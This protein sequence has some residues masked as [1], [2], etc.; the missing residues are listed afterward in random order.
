MIAA[1]RL[2]ELVPIEN[3]AMPGRTVIQ[4]EKDDLE[5]LGLLKVDVL[6]LGMLSAIRRALDLLNGYWFEGNAE[7]AKERK[8]RREFYETTSQSS[9]RSLRYSVPSA[10]SGKWTLTLA[11]ATAADSALAHPMGAGSD[12]VCGRG[13]AGGFAGSE[14]LARQ[15]FFSPEAK[16]PRNSR[17]AA[18]RRRCRPPRRRPRTPPSRAPSSGSARASA[19]P[20]RLP[21]GLPC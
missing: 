8:D 11:E 12:H 5:A 16:D 10:F 6:A 14:A 20:D 13:D 15:R 21:A 2:D 3:A 19:R 4:W 17:A 18:S 9:L 7:N 1:G